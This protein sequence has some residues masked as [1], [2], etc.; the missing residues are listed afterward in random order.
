[1]MLKKFGANQPQQLPGHGMA[2]R[3]CGRE[4]LAIWLVLLVMSFPAFAADFTDKAEVQGFIEE[5]VADHGFVKSELQ[6]VLANAQYKQSIIDAITRPAEKTLTWKEY[7]KI[8][9]T[10]KRIR[11][12]K[13]FIREHEQILAQAEKE[14]GVPVP[15]IAAVLG[16]ETFYGQ[17]MGNYRVIDALAT[18][19]FDYPPRASFF[20]KQLVEFLILA[21]EEKQ[22]E[23]SLLGSYAGAMGYGQFIPSSYRSF[24]VDFDGDGIRDIWENPADAIGSVANYFSA[25]HW[26]TGKPVTDRLTAVSEAQ[27]A[28]FGKKLEPYIKAADL[29]SQGIEVAAGIDAEELVTPLL[30]LGSDGEEYWLGYYNFYVITRYNHSPLYAMAVYQLSR[31]LM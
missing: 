24:A 3:W 16:V 26:Q 17:R 2:K 19:A 22:D 14:Y 15:V 18:L 30:F 31:E 10:D 11:E 1:M 20:R 25:H 8:F 13:K 9:L 23:S 28:L 4:Q 7:R 12:G 6:H 27:G 21:R 5:M 29:N